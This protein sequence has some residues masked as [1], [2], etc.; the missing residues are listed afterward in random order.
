MK[1][2]K[3]K[4]GKQN[5]KNIHEGLTKEE[6]ERI[7]AEKK[8]TLKKS[9]IKKMVEQKEE[10]RK[11]DKETKE[12]IIQEKKEFQYIDKLKGEELEKVKNSKKDICRSREKKHIIYDR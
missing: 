12:K 3:L 2:E 5:A 1:K 4:Q 7:K 6:V 9:K 11:L 10:F 8:E